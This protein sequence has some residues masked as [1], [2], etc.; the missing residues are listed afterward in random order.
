LPPTVEQILDEAVPT[1]DDGTAA[2]SRPAARTV[3]PVPP[4]A[5]PRRYAE[6]AAEYHYVWAD[7][8]RIALVAG[9]L[10]LLL[11]ILSLFIR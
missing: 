11:V 4:R 2:L 9:G 3:A 5:A 8:R 6:Y 10:V 1:V 7:L